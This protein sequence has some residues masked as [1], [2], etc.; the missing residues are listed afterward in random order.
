MQP[1]DD[2][3]SFAETFKEK[4]RHFVSSILLSCHQILRSQTLELVIFWTGL[5]LSYISFFSISY[6]ASGSEH[7]KKLFQNEKYNFS[8]W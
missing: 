6:Q 7:V 8:L 5:M 2:A 4:R 1:V 3:S